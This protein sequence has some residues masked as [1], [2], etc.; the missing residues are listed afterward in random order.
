MPLKSSGNKITK[1]KVNKKDIVIS[2]G[3]NE[4]I[5]VVKEVMANFY[6]YV[7]KELSKKEI[8]EIVEFSENSIYLRYALSLLEKSHYSEWKMREKLYAK[9]ANKS[10]TDRIIKLLKHNDLIDDKAYALDLYYY[11]E[12]KNYGKNKIINYIKDKG[13]FDESMK[14]LRFSDSNEKKKALINLPKL[15][16]KYSKYSYQQKK[17][18]IYSALIGLGFESDIALSTLNK[19]REPKEKEEKAKLDRDFQNC[20]NKMKRKY[21]G[22]ELKEKVYASLRNKGYRSNDILKKWEDYYAEND[23]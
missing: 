13:I 10:A 9:G 19:V 2:F 22:R 18:H 17:E 3:K 14:Q 20:V 21:E 8:N 15:E 6:L 11:L 23:F 16:K 5:R 1:I 12:E 7:G 4:S